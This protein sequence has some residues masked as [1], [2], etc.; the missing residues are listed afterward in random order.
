MSDS[1]PGRDDAAA[2]DAEFIRKR[3]DQ[4]PDGQKRD[5][6]Y[7]PLPSALTVP[8][9][10]NH[11]HLEIQDGEGLDY[12]EH[13]DRASSVGIRGVVQVGNDLETSRWSAEIAAREPRVLAAVALHPNEAPRY[14]AEGRLDEALAEIDELAGRPASGRSARPDSTGSGW[15]RTG[16]TRPS[17]VEPRSSRS[18]PT[19]RSP[20]S[21]A[22][23]SRSTTATRTTTSSRR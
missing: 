7:P 6:S 23:P 22:S 1:Q 16:A 19:S 15:G 20:R 4:A 11:T 21:T 9:Y 18:K 2:R 14:A 12:R 13:L 8:V 3:A 10:D 17:R 5:L